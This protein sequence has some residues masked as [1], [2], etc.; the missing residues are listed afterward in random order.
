MLG[1]T[2]GKLLNEYIDIGNIILK[3]NILFKNFRILKQ[4]R[5]L[6]FHLNALKLCNLNI[7]LRFC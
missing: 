2:Q 6:K 1:N 3:G 5:I 7:Y 4:S